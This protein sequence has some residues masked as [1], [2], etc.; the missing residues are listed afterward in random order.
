VDFLATVD[1]TGGNSGSPVLNGAGELVGLLFDGNYESTGDEFV[2][3]DEK[4][5]SI[6][7]DLRYIHWMISRVDRV[8]GLQDELG[9]PPLSKLP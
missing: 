2:F 6:C 5:R 4:Q 7:V 8:K 9:W 3:W 1:T